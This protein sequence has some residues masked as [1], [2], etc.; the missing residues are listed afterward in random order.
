MAFGQKAQGRGCRSSTCAS[1][2]FLLSQLSHFFWFSGLG[3]L[4]T[5]DR[6][7]H[8]TD[9][10]KK[11]RFIG[12]GAGL[13]SGT[14]AFRSS[15]DGLGPQFFSSSWLGSSL[16]ARGPGWLL[17]AAQRR[18]KGFFSNVSQENSGAQWSDLTRT[19]TPGRI[20]EAEGAAWTGHAEFCVMLWVKIQ[21][22]EILNPKEALICDSQGNYD[23]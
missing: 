9:L 23:L 1:L 5:R 12:P 10:S 14:A 20:P 15:N 22:V 19:P 3:F 8:Q 17:T 2:R 7:I 16:K 13:A 21:E 18:R 4:E 6:I 11:E